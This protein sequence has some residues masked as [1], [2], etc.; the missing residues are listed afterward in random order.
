MHG[1]ICKM[2]VKQPETSSIF[3][4]AST[5]NG[6][7]K[8]NNAESNDEIHKDKMTEKNNQS[9]SKLSESQTSTDVDMKVRELE[10]KLKDADN[11]LVNLRAEVGKIQKICL[12]FV[13]HTLVYETIWRWTITI[14]IKMYKQE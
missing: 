3:S 9:K 12:I 5:T 14:P 13:C 7:V 8:N 4:Q 1:F 6:R 2:L 10:R 11:L